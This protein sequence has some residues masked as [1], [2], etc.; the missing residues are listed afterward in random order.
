MGLTK[1]RSWAAAIYILYK[2]PQGQVGNTRIFAKYL[3]FWEQNG[4]LVYQNPC[5]TVNSAVGEIGHCVKE[6]SSAI[7]WFRVN[8][9]SGRNWGFQ[10]EWSRLVGTWWLQ[11]PWTISA[12]GGA[13][14]T[15]DGLLGLFC[16]ILQEKLRHSPLAHSD[17]KS[18]LRILQHSLSKTWFTS[19]MSTG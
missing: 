16:S 10:S 7:R 11:W 1:V 8:R 4:A 6:R 17:G 14:E 5:Q 19:R 2:G 15:D 12:N 9:R 3:T 13:H 18:T